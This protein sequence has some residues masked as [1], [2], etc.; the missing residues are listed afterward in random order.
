MWKKEYEKCPRSI[1]HSLSPVPK[2]GSHPLIN[3]NG[4]TAC[5][6]S[7]NPDENSPYFIQTCARLRYLSGWCAAM[8][9][10]SGEWPAQQDPV[11]S[12]G[13]PGQPAGDRPPLGSGCG[14]GPAGGL[15]E[16]HE[17][18]RS[19]SVLWCLQ[20]GKA[21][22]TNK[23]H[24]LTPWPRSKQGH[25]RRNIAWQ[26][27]EWRGRRRCQRDAGSQHLPAPLSTHQHLQIG[28][29]GARGGV[30]LEVK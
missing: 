17:S 25:S 9:L 11:A 27:A 30:N 29:Q 19:C 14:P 4:S 24:L 7:R 16:N 28:C 3:L 13:A 2:C 5:F 22:V 23:R 10:H 26:P 1:I 6:C 8:T 12:V 15:A 21:P 18:K 20:D